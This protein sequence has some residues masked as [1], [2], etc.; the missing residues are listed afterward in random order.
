M[1]LLGGGFKQPRHFSSQASLVSV[2]IQYGSAWGKIEFSHIDPVVISRQGV[3]KIDPMV[4]QI[5]KGGPEGG[6]GRSGPAWKELEGPK[7]FHH[8]VHGSEQGGD[9]IC[10]NG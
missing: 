9:E 2:Q 4:G 10:L 7:W 3:G 5:I 1:P 6:P 8:S